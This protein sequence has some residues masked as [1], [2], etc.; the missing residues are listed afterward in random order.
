MCRERKDCSGLCPKRSFLG[1]IRAQSKIWPCRVKGLWRREGLAIHRE[2]FKSGFMPCRKRRCILAG[3]SGLS[4]K[5]SGQ[6]SCRLCAMV[7][8]SFWTFRTWTNGLICRKRLSRDDFP[9]TNISQ[10]F[11]EKSWNRMNCRNGGRFMDAAR[12][13]L[14][15]PW[16]SMSCPLVD[17]SG[18]S[19]RSRRSCILPFDALNWKEVKAGLA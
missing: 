8:E 7:D 11:I 12:D 18:E 4:E 16:E 3:P 1:T 15:M 14:P 2:R 19:G 6:G 10:W 13:G 5:W 9:L 17:G